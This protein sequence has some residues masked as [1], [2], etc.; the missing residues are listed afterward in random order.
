MGE[1]SYKVFDRF[2][3]EDESGEKYEIL[4]LSKHYSDEEKFTMHPLIYVSLDGSHT[5]LIT[6]TKEDNREVLRLFDLDDPD[7]KEKHVTRVKR[8]A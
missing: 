2:F 7:K 8:N 3:A 5:E 1:K 6:R 4:A